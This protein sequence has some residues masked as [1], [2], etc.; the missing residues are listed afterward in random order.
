MSTD[1]L[2]RFRDGLARGEFTMTEI[3][4]ATGIPLTTLSDM[5]SADWRPKV[6]DRLEKLS[7]ALDRI[8]RPATK[9]KSRNG[10]AQATA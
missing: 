2:K 1:A 5:S 6:F 3:A 10:K 7:V 9:T 4:A 8:K